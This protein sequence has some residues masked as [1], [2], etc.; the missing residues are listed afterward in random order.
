MSQRFL[1][2]LNVVVLGGNRD[3]LRQALTEPHS[4][5]SLHVDGEWLKALLEPTDGEVA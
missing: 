4:D 5:V 3:K 2:Y 1:K